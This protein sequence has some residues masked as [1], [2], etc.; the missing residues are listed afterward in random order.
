MTFEQA[1]RFLKVDCILFKQTTRYRIIHPFVVEVTHIEK[2]P[3]NT[4][5]NTI[6]YNA[7]PGTGKTWYEYQVKNVINEAAFEANKEIELG[8]EAPWTINDILG[9]GEEGEDTITQY[10]K[11]ML[12]IVEKVE[13]AIADAIAQNQQLSP[14]PSSRYY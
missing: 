11:Y 12:I 7:I 3:I 5:E 10:V 2:V 9:I 1:P 13:R 8:K 14:I 6:K 4:V